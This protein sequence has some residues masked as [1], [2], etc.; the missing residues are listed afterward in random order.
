MAELPSPEGQP[1]KEEEF[2]LPIEVEI[3]IEPD[4]SVT[5]ADLEAG[6]LPIAQQLDPNWQQGE[7]EICL[8]P[9]NIKQTD[10]ETEEDA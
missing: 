7:G 5:F 1:D 2:L 9:S 8:P 10:E 6:T 4:G 3:Y